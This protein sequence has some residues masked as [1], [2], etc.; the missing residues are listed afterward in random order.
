MPREVVEVELYSFLTL[1]LEGV[2]VQHHAPTALPPGPAWTCA[3]NLA[4][5]GIRSPDCP[6]HS[7]SQ[8]RLRYLGC[9]F[10]VDEHEINYRTFLPHKPPVPQTLY[11]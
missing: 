9:H 10:K 4:L 3:K 6:A 2:G 5:T 1:T 7:Q 11:C 8:Y